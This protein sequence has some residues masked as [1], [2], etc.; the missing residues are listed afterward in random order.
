ML[1]I[2]LAACVMLSAGQTLAASQYYIQHAT[3][4]KCTV[5]QHKPNGKSE[6]Q[7]GKAFKTM[8]EAER[9]MKSAHECGY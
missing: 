6:M 4:G 1:R 5:S 8:T 9:A 2:V 3:G 7:V